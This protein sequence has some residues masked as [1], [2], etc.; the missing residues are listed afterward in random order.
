MEKECLY[1]E[2]HDI[3]TDSDNELR[4]IC[5]KVES[6]NFLTEVDCFDYCEEFETEGNNEEF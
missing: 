6:R 2:H 1:C 4:W 5:T 3:I